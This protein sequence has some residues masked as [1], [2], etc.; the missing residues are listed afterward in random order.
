MK[1]CLERTESNQQNLTYYGDSSE[2]KNYLTVFFNLSLNVP[3]QCLFRKI[4]LKR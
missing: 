4:Q 2:K 1:L 3:Y